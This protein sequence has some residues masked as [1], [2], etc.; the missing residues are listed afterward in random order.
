MNET[1]RLHVLWAV[2]F[3]TFVLGAFAFG[4]LKGMDSYSKFEMLSRDLASQLK[5]SVEIIESKDRAIESQD[6]TIEAKDKVIQVLNEEIHVITVTS[7]NLAREANRT[8]EIANVRRQVAEKYVGAL[9][10]RIAELEATVEL[11]KSELESTAKLLK[12]AR[13]LLENEDDGKQD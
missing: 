11:Y 12:E 6:D 7:K 5:D 9:K 13:A 1:T 4:N 10:D 2:T 3:A 8:I